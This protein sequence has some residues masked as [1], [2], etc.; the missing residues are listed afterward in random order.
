MSTPLSERIASAS[1]R[2][3]EEED[4][5]IREAVQELALY[6]LS[7]TR[8]FSEA[9]FHGGTFLRILHGLDRFSEDLDFS[10]D[11]P[12]P[13]FDWREHTGTLIDILK[14]HGLICELRPKAANS[15]PAKAVSLVS[16]GPDPLLLRFAHRTGRLIRVKLEVDTDPPEGAAT[17]ISYADFPATHALRCFDLPS[18][19]AGKCHAILCRSHLKGRDLYDFSWYV[20]RGIGPNHVLLMSALLQ[21]GPWKGDVGVL[22]DPEW[23][24]QALRKRMSEIDWEDARRDAMPFLGEAGRRSLTLWGEGFF[25]DRIARLDRSMSRNPV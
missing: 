25:G 6:A 12:E 9:A 5:A 14:A 21:S 18:G 2:T 11:R 16:P 4:A 3:P 15:A 8:F 22:P 19:M 24:V 1:P 17:A 7:G 13:G 20:G 23:L 10:T